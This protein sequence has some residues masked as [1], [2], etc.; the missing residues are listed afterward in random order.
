MRVVECDSAVLTLI[1]SRQGK[2]MDERTGIVL[3]RLFLYFRCTSFF[4]FR[5]SLSLALT[6]VFK[7]LYDISRELRNMGNG[8]FH[9]REDFGGKRYGAIHTSH[10]HHRHRCFRVSPSSCR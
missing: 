6:V 7:P 3:F 8:I 4:S 10:R 9:R 5:F 2:R 1:A